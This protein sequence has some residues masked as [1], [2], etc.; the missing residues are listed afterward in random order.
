MNNE[1]IRGKFKESP[2]LKILVDWL[3]M[4]PVQTRPAK[5]VCA[6]AGTA[7]STPREMLE[8]SSFGANGHPTLPKILVGRL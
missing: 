5:M 2:R 4:N 7:L 1:E 6:H 8:D 3:I